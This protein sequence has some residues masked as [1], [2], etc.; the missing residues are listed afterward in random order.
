V[1]RKRLISWLLVIVATA[2]CAAQPADPTSRP[3]STTRPDDP[4]APVTADW[5]RS[6]LDGRPCAPPCLLG[7][8]PG[9]STQTATLELMS[10]SFPA[11][12]FDKVRSSSSEPSFMT[13]F[14]TGQNRAVTA[15]FYER[16]PRFN[17]APVDTITNLHISAPD[18]PVFSEVIAA[19]GEPSHVLALANDYDQLGVRYFLSVVYIDRGI[20]L[21]FDTNKGLERPQLAPDLAVYQATFFPASLETFDASLD[22][23][24]PV[25]NVSALLVPWQGF[26]PF[27]AYCRDTR[28]DAERKGCQ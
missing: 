11:A 15:F 21:W 23:L 10:A 3:I 5:Q 7:I 8:T 22:N 2:G 14:W 12:E 27:A 16:P 25:R 9:T 26:Q 6:W 4:H 18:L 28:P 17:N 19:F 20:L 13:W 24:F 1:L